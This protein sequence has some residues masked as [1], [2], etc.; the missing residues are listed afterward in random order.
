MM[1]EVGQ[2][3][4]KAPPDDRRKK[5]RRCYCCSCVAAV[6]LLLALI[7]L[8]LALTVFKVKDPTTKVVSSSVEGFA[9]TISFPQL[10]LQLNITLYTQLLVHNPN[11]ASFRHDEGSSLLF[12]HGIQIGDVDIMPG[13]IPADG[14]ETFGTRV[15]IDADR[16]I[17]NLAF[18]GEVFSGVMNIESRS[19][20]PGRVTILGVFRR[21]VV[22]SAICQIAINTRNMTIE[23]QKCIFDTKL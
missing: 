1:T 17:T 6:L 2:T 8:I 13:L 5:R 10:R 18:I 12:F 9:T 21:H 11:R 15:T 7:I 20:I 23:S 14:S 22:S 4:G 16:V 19:T 3:G